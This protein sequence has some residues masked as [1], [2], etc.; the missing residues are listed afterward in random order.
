MEITTHLFAI[1]QNFA[2]IGVVLFWLF[3]AKKVTDFADNYASGLDSDYEI[4]ERSNLAVGLRR[5]GIYLGTII[6]ML[7][8]LLG[9]SNGFGADL[10]VFFYEGAAVT[11]F[12]VIA[13]LWIGRALVGE[14]TSAAVGE[15]NEA[16]GIV[17]M[18]AY[19]ATGLITLGSFVGEGGGIGTV[20]A[21]FI[22]GQLSLFLLVKLY[23]AVTPLNFAELVRDYNTAA[24]L[25]LG[26]VILSFGIILAAAISG[27]FNGWVESFL[28]FGFYAVAG[29]VLLFITEKV[30]DWLFLPTTTIEVEIGRDENEAAA[31][32][33][34]AVLV[35]VALSL[36]V[37]VI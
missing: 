1:L 14:K 16:V 5:T 29:A 21:F 4:G 10:A 8:P 22:A 34:A 24:G 36:S 3:V 35:A 12:M 28:S 20:I 2:F 25:L 33:T 7:G 11:A 31:L 17:A 37:A 27:P 26:G 15:H 6:G 23:D 18:A 30:A 13:G 9:E 19:I 32:L